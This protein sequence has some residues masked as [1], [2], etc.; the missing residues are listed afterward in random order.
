E[1]LNVQHRMPVLKL[2]SN[3]RALL[4]TT[5]SKLGRGEAD[6]DEIQPAGKRETEQVKRGRE[7]AK[8]ARCAACHKIPAMEADLKGVPTLASPR[9]QS[10]DASAS[11]LDWDNSCLSKADRAANRPHYPRIDADAIK[12]YVNS[13]TG[14]LSPPTQFARGQHVLEERNCLGCHERDLT[15]GIV[16]VAG[17]V[18]AQIDSL[19]GESEA[20][21]PPALTAIGDKLYDEPLATAVSGLQKEV[22]LPWLHVRMPRFDHTDHEKEALLAYLIG[23]DRIPDG[24]P[25]SLASPR[26]RSGDASDPEQTSTTDRTNPEVDATGSPEPDPQ[27]LVIGRSLAGSGGFNCVACHAF[28][29]YEP[30]NVALGTKG[31]D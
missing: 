7:L 10:G 26:R 31:S 9:R 8:A 16:P 24:A 17:S 25:T 21:I 11:S 18:A 13:R 15:K 29:E 14:E 3:E 6:F 20:L 23:H 30:R 5:L 2:T 1:R 22:R 27:T 28:G 12:A 19:R 4:A